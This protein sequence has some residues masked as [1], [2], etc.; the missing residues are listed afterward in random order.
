MIHEVQ[1]QFTK[2]DNN[3]NDKVIKEKYLVAEAESF[4][5][6]ETQ[7][8]DHC[9]GET[10]LDVINV[11]RSKVKE[12]INKRDTENQR[13]FIGDVADVRTNDEGEEVEIVY[14]VALFALDFD[15]AYKKINEWLKQ[16]Y[17]MTAI[18]MKK[19]KFLDVI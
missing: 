14:K 17:D 16:G 13:I 15:D 7:G 9:D 2:I 5:D 3:G 19:T 18:G 6:A 12:I 10:D 11:K 4:G 8:Y 1:V